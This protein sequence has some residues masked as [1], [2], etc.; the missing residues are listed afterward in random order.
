M[1]AFSRRVAS[2][3]DV[4]IEARP[5]ATL[6]T[7]LRHVIRGAETHLIVRRASNTRFFRLA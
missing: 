6:F 5:D 3:C 7:E 2:W 4:P 1:A